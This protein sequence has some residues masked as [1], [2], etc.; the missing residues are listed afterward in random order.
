MKF[1]DGGTQDIY[2]GV[3]SKAS[4]RI[5]PSSLVA[6]AQLKLIVLEAAETLDSLKIPPG[7]R[8][9]ALKGDRLGQH[10]IRINEQYR[11]C[12]IWAGEQATNVQI[13]DYH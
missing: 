6:K 10:S 1:A 12:F 8:L 11:I 4:R 2:N 9:E 13:V 5:C 3:S 7:N